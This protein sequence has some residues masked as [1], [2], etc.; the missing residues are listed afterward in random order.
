MPDKFKNPFRRVL[1]YIPK[2]GGMDT[3]ETTALW[4]IFQTY[5]SLSKNRRL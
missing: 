4:K 1:K 3:F 2:P 5:N